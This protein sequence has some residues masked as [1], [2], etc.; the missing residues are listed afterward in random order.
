VEVDP[1]GGRFPIALVAGKLQREPQAMARK[2][3][4]KDCF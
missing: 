4:D 2:T 1:S 3:H